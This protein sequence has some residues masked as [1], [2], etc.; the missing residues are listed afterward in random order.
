MEIIVILCHGECGQRDLFPVTTPDCAVACFGFSSFG[1]VSSRSQ[2]T[3]TEV[4]PRSFNV[5]SQPRLIHLFSFLF[6]CLQTLP[7]CKRLLVCERSHT[8]FQPSW[9]QCIL[10]TPILDLFNGRASGEEPSHKLKS[11]QLL[12]EMY[13]SASHPEKNWGLFSFNSK[14]HFIQGGF[15]LHLLCQDC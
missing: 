6:A 5:C 15:L 4:E 1:G 3:L 2:S 8:G 9:E 11:F 14:P 13:G 10:G 7:S 12:S